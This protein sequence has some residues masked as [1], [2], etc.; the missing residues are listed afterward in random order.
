MFHWQATIMG[1]PDSPY[2]GGVFLVT[3]HFPPDYPFKPPKGFSVEAMASKQIL[4]ESKDLP[5]HPLIFNL[6]SG[7]DFPTRFDSTTTDWVIDSGASFHFTPQ[8]NIFDDDYNCE[9]LGH[10]SVANGDN[11]R[12]IGKG[13]VPLKILGGRSLVLKGTRH[14]PE[15]KGNLI[16]IAV[17]DEEGFTTTF[18]DGHWKITLGEDLIAMGDRV[19]FTISKNTISII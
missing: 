3:I 1:P 6:G 9:D 4:K 2:A 10:A 16:S 12:I 11:C 18:G 13:T 14:V 17:L 7:S 8:I 19:H 15:L 5:E